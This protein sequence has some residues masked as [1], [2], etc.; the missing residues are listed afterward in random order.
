MQAR[1]VSNN[2]WR[3][4]WTLWADVVTSFWCLCGRQRLG[5]GC[6]GSDSEC[7]PKGV[8]IRVSG[9]LGHS[10]LIQKCKK[11]LPGFPS[12]PQQLAQ[13][14]S[15]WPVN[16]GPPTE[17]EPLWLS[18]QWCLRMLVREVKKPCCF[19]EIPKKE[20]ERKHGNMC[21]HEFS[22]TERKVADTIHQCQS[23]RQAPGVFSFF[24][25]LNVSPCLLKICF[26][27]GTIY[28]LIAYDLRRSLLKRKISRTRE[29]ELCRLLASSFW[30]WDMFVF[31][32][33]GTFKYF[34]LWV[35]NDPS[36]FSRYILWPLCGETNSKRG[37]L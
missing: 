14:S 36:N 33:S 1:D 21:Q 2:T 29:R 28:D 27:K 11:R 13:L 19:W 20:N 24:L 15:W 7:L 12:G 8:S 34:C 18:S 4:Y 3:N 5:S 23:P 35:R 31:T 26:L 6:V 16:P 32:R 10:F 25:R 30:I 37:R 17:G 9:M 22:F